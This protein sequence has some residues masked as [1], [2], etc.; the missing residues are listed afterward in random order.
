MLK[1]GIGAGHTKHSSVEFF[2]PGICSIC[3]LWLLSSIAA[4]G[5]LSKIKVL[6][7]CEVGNRVCSK[8]ALASA[9]TL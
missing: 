1:V 5:L 6:S 4:E 9:Y 2:L 3:K 8:S 7:E